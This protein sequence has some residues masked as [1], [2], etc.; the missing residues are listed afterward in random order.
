VLSSPSKKEKSS[1][2]DSVS[3][4]SEIWNLY[5]GNGGIIGRTN[6]VNAGG[7]DEGEKQVILSSSSSSSSSSPPKP[8]STNMFPNSSPTSNK[9]SRVSYIVQS[10]KH[11]HDIDGLDEDDKNEVMVRKHEAEEIGKAPLR[12]RHKR[13]KVVVVVVI[14]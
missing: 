5:T 12:R 10:K 11:D 8:S 14:M 4:F 7:E 2:N 3:F 13:L 1:E 6:V 9:S